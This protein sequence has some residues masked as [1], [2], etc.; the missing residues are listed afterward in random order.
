MCIGGVA[1]K[2]CGTVIVAESDPDEGW[3]RK[4]GQDWEKRGSERMDEKRQKEKYG[5]KVGKFFI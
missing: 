3:P 5:K 2:E 1:A 4:G